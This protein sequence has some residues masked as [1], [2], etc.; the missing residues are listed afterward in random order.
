MKVYMLNPP[1]FPHF[2][3]EMRWQDTGRGGD[4]ILPNMAILCYW[5]VG[6]EWA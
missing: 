1:Y 4:F 2:G 6:K 5:I 3:R